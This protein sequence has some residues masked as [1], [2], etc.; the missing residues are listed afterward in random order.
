[1][2]LMSNYLKFSLLFDSVFSFQFFA[3]EVLVNLYK[4]QI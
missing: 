4:E 3:L 1:M 2:T